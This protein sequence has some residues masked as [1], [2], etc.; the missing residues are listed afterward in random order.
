M[1]SLLQAYALKRTLESLDCDV[2]F[3]DIEKN[4][5]DYNLLGNFRENYHEGEKSGMVGKLSKVDRY[6]ANRLKIKCAAKRQDAL[7]E[8]FRT[9]TLSL[10][11]MHKQYDVCVIGS[12]EVFNCLNAGEWGFTA[13]LFGNVPEAD[14]VI[15]YA[16]SCGA[17]NFKNLPNGVKG[18]IAEVFPR[19][20]GVS[21]R[22]KNTAD[23]ASH[24]TIRSIERH[25][26]PVLICDFEKEIQGTLLP[27]LPDRYCVIYSYYN[28]IHTKE[29]INSIRKFCKDR[30]LTPVAV[31]APQ[32]WLENYTVCSPF[33]CLKVFK[34][35]DFVITDTFHGTIFSYKYA[36]KFAVMTRMSNYNK[37]RDLISRLAIEDHLLSENDIDDI[38]ER[39]R[40]LSGADQILHSER[41]RSEA[42]LANFAG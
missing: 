5:D 27:K 33:Q 14:R 8:E 10:S 32:F 36:K 15:T 23:F 19:I 12:D 37:L 29:E 6:I 31:G 28:R 11:R 16:A 38:F 7:F 20:E 30:M 18:R 2:E 40:D 39:E 3:I 41:E 35:A 26:D 25:L 24:F 9:H 34:E 1:G 4:I 21:V 22:D 17:T 42:Y 13:Q